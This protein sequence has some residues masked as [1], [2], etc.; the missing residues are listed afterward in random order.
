MQTECSPALFDFAPVEGRRIVAAFDGGAITSNADR[1]VISGIVHMLKNGG[2]WQDCPAC[3]GPPTT[4]YSR[5]HRWSGRSIWASVLAALVEAT[6]GGLHLIDSTTAKAHRSAAD[7]KGGGPPGYRPLAWRQR[8][9]DP[10]RQR[11]PGPDPRLRH[12]TGAEGDARPAHGLLANLPP[13]DLCRG[14]TAYDSDGLRLFLAE[15]GT[16]PVIPNNSTRK[17]PHPFDDR[18]YK[19]RNIIE[20]TIGRLKDWR[21]I[22]TRYD[23]R[24]RNFASAV[25]IAAI[26]LG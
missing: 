21:R 22:H 5:Y 4:I 24:A 20:R 10:P 25:A 16:T 3:Y 13:P 7:G 8:H 12:H 17:R 9:E 19:A 23:K 2:R 18:A 6:P 11:R 14:D 15:R 1:R 26:L